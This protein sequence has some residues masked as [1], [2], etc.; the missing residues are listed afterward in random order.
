MRDDFSAWKDE[1][2]HSKAFQIL[3]GGCSMMTLS[4]SLDILPWGE[5]CVE[6]SALEVKWI[7]NG[8]L[9]ISLY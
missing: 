1:Q 2:W 3:A 5:I 7:Y 9:Q 4:S 6:P 8:D